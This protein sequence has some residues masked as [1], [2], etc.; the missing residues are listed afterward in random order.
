EIRIEHRNERLAIEL[1]RGSR[2]AVQHTTLRENTRTI[3]RSRQNLVGIVE[4]DDVRTVIC[5]V[6]VIRRR[7]AKL[8]IDVRPRVIRPRG[9]S[10]LRRSQSAVQSSRLRAIR[11][12]SRR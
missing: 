3:E 11:E 8:I 10:A 1:M 6:C 4:D 5:K 9:Q 7:A 2:R 12:K